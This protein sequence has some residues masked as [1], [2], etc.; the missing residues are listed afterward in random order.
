MEA[1]LTKPP[2]DTPPA[3]IGGPTAWKGRDMGA[4]PDRWL[5]RLSDDE[6]T[7]ID[8]A[9]GHVRQ[10]RLAL[11]D[12]TPETFRLPRLGARL[13]HLL[14]HQL[15]HGP[16]FALLRGI[17]V[18]RY[19]VEQAAIAYL[20]IGSYLGTFRSQ[21]AK[22]HLLGHVRDL[23]LDIRE[24]GTRYYQTT[25]RLD[26]HTDSCDIVGL[27]CLK[28]PKSGGESRIVS[29]VTLFNEM[30]ARRPDLVAQLFHA[31]PTDRRGEVPPGMRPWFEVPVFNWLDRQLTTIYVGQ[32]I[33]SAQENFA[34]ARRLT[35]VEIEALD[36]LD[37]LADDAALR[38]DM[39]FLPGDM[40]FLHNHQ[41]LHSR[42]DFD[43]WPEPERKRH[44]LRLW[45]AP[46]SARS[47]PACFAARYGSLEP[48]QRGGIVTK[49]TRL[50]FVLQ[51][52]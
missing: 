49:E 37:A 42:T 48:G 3:R 4:E 29:S 7:E 15:L 28:T 33:R 25:R 45:L 8:A 50:K 16:G 34:E 22:G 19:S 17:P 30:L 6:L 31:F 9:V 14:Q 43:D 12:I 32:Y 5:F 1:E 41:I 2:L 21:N 52:E 40:Q 44:L 20:G 11:G 18:D 27:L 23:G 10:S 39:D 26:Y 47:L 24:K 46:P 51:P 13:K 36:Y 38:L 35:D